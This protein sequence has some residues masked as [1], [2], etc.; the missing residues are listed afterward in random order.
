MEI[1][2]N[3]AKY[4]VEKKLYV[5]EGV[6]KNLSSELHNLDKVVVL[7]SFSNLLDRAK[8][9]DKQYFDL[10]CEYFDLSDD[11][12]KDHTMSYKE[13]SGNLCAKCNN[14]L[15]FFCDPSSFTTLITHLIMMRLKKEK[16]AVLGNEHRNIF[17]FANLINQK[18][19]LGVVSIFYNNSVFYI[20]M[21][22]PKKED[23][24]E[25]GSRIFVPA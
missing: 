10:A 13:L 9:S 14:F 24:I 11:I 21:S 16:E 22:Y 3:N 1:E 6:V 25:A 20:D 4:F 8:N 19:F 5:L 18:I 2:I 23:K 15:P 12:L 17:F 7:P